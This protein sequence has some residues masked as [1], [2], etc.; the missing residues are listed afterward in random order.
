[1]T[2]TR[3]VRENWLGMVLGAAVVLVVVALPSRA[4]AQNRNGTVVLVQYSF[5]SGNPQLIVQQQD[6]SNPP[7]TVSFLAPR[8]P[9]GGCSV[10][11]QLDIDTIKTG[12]SIAQA[13]KLS[14]KSTTVYYTSCNG[15]NYLTDLVMVN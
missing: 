5:N 4:F 3:T 12:Q 2:K 11:P 7:S 8:T 15:A 14:G 9:P 13:A 10:V 6:S 1:M